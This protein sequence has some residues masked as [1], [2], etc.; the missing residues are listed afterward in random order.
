MTHS[1]RLP[2]APRHR[3]ALA[4]AAS[5]CC[6]KVDLPAQAAANDNAVPLPQKPSVPWTTGGNGDVGYAAEPYLV[7]SH[8]AQLTPPG[9]ATIDGFVPGATPDA[10]PAAVVSAKTVNLTS[11]SYAANPDAALANAIGGQGSTTSYAGK[12]YQL[13]PGSSVVSKGAFS[14]AIGPDTARIL[15][16]GIPAGSVVGPATTS[17]IEYWSAQGI[18]VTLTHF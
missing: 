9:T 10:P 14:I 6:S 16:I 1:T 15:S 4:R 17:A 8:G 5:P 2:P 18:T 3:A 12:L 11:P 13:S 7:E